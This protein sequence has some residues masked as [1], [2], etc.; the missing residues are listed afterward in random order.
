VATIPFRSVERRS[1]TC[2][3]QPVSLFLDGRMTQEEMW[4]TYI[5]E[6]KK[7][8]T[9]LTFDDKE[10][11]GQ[12]DV[13]G[14]DGDE[15]ED[16]TSEVLGAHFNLLAPCLSA[17]AARSRSFRGT[18]IK[19]AISAAGTATQLTLKGGGSAALRGCL[20]AALAQIR[21]QRHGGAPRQVEYPMLIK[22]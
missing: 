15:G 21:F 16:R 11:S 1:F 22:R 5:V 9:Q 14:T 10:A 17:E 4:S 7:G 13:S 18:T 8:G 6:K 12:T 20:Q 2:Q 19:F 3:G